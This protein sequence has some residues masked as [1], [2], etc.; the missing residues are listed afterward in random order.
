MTE[1][2]REFI[3]EQ[4]KRLDPLRFKTYSENILLEA[5]DHIERQAQ[6]IAELQKD[7]AEVRHLL[8][9]SLYGLG[10]ITYESWHTTAWVDDEIWTKYKELATEVRN[11]FSKKYK[12]L[13]QRIAELEAERQW[14]SVSERLPEE[15]GGY[16]CRVIEKSFITQT[17]TR[18]VQWFIDKW[19]S[20]GEVTHWQPLPQP[21]KEEE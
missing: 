17:H 15:D 6:R 2:T 3:A 1:F 21:P 7:N 4:R 11:E 9:F 10:K 8:A 14:I 19:C 12:A 16:L 18:F 20:Y 5:L 13:Q